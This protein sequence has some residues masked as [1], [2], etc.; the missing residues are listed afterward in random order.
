MSSSQISKSRPLIKI[1]TLEE[2]EFNENMERENILREKTHM[3]DQINK[4]YDSVIIPF[5]DGTLQI[6]SPSVFTFM[7]REIFTQWIIDNNEHVRLILG[8]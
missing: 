8:Y 1:I 5:Q 4:L 7:T 3:I 2:K 6:S